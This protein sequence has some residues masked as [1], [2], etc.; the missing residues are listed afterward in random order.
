MEEI[1]FRGFL[2]QLALLMPSRLL[3]YLVLVLSVILF[4]ASHISM[5][6]GQFLSK[7][8]LGIF[9]LTPVLLTQCIL[10]AI[11]IHVIFNIFAY[12]AMKT[13]TQQYTQKRGFSY[14]L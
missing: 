7:T 14:A 12:H 4:G 3:T 9:C 8:I 6:R 5:G 11:L 2:W 1:I 10:P 13:T